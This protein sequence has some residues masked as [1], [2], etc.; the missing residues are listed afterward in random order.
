MVPTRLRSAA[1]ALLALAVLG[2]GVTSPPRASAQDKAK[3]DQE[4]IQGTWEVVS[5]EKGGEKLPEEIVKAIKITFK[6][7]KLSLAHGDDA[8]EATFKLDPA[9]KPRHLD[10]NIDGKT[11]EA[12]YA[13][14][15]KNLKICAGEP[16]SPRPKDF[17]GEGENIFLVLKRAGAEKG[18]CDDCAPG[19][20]VAGGDKVKP[21]KKSDQERFQGEWI[22]VAAEKGG[23]K[24]PDEIL[25]GLKL[26]VK[27]DAIEL[28]ILGETKKGSLK[29]DPTTKPKS[30]DLMVEGKTIKGIYQFEKDTLK[31]CSGEPCQERPKEFKADAGSQNILVIFKR[32]AGEKKKG[33]GK[34]KSSGA[35]AA[36]KKFQGA[37]VVVSAEKGGEKIPDEFIKTIKI[38]FTED[39]L[40]FEL[41]GESK[42]GTFKVDPT[43]KP[44]AIDLSVDDKKA[45]GIYAF[46][47]DNLKV[48]IGEP[49]QARPKE[50]SGAG[51]DQMLVVLKRAKSCD[52]EG[53]TFEGSCQDAAPAAGGE[54]DKGEKGG[55]RAKLQGTWQA[56]SLMKG[57]KEMPEA[58]V[59]SIK[60]TFAAD[61]V[62]IHKGDGVSKDGTYKLDATKK[63]R[64]IDITIGD[65]TGLGIYQLEGNTLT[66]CL[67]EGEGARPSEFKSEPGTRQVLVV[68]KR[69][70][71]AKEKGAEKGALNPAGPEQAQARAADTCQVGAA[72]AASA[73]SL[74]IIGLA[75]HN[76]HDA[77]R[78]FPAAAIHG[79]DGKPLLSWRV[80][81][82]P[83]LE[84]NNLYR[85]FKLDEPWDSEHNKKLLAKIPQVYA[86]IAGN[87]KEPHSTYFRV[88][89]GPGT[90]FEGDK[91]QRIAAV[92]DGTSNTILAV[93]AGA[94]VP[95][96]KPDELPFTPAGKLPKLGGLSQGGFNILMADGSVRFIRR[97]FDAQTLRGAITRNGGEVVDLDKLSP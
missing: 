80:A 45:E 26:A 65:K 74:K 60:M 61:K 1:T 34:E 84:Q 90:L 97:D 10:A 31:V 96:T 79:K 81:L 21:G 82:L 50:F 9:K 11:I 38:T 88:F 69:A 33:G 52:G 62:S 87:A 24:V 66:L 95:W 14:E 71:A 47:G 58:E 35:G 39:R 13:L 75:M 19:A 57:G 27:G 42:D 16:A 77:N 49:G 37:W 56:R 46:E 76:Y 91:G 67:T 41:G 94:A 22:V 70:K 4:L 2:T 55:D 93:E 17:K 85:Q 68:L 6:G 83:Y 5:G 51:A 72:R 12:I 48:C 32:A 53:A 40:K 23:E 18:K 28:E 43:Q 36:L 89:T 78:S 25:K 59:K 7:D 44:A 8:K 73:N 64:E 86:P 29:L 92:T 3:S 54:K 30:I 20:A 15:G 63:P